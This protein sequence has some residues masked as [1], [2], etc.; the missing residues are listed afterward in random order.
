MS[1]DNN[2]LTEI[3]VEQALTVW[4]DFVEL[5]NSDYAL[6]FFGVGGIFMGVIAQYNSRL[7]S[8]TN[9]KILRAYKA[10][11]ILATGICVIGIAV[12]ATYATTDDKTSFWLIHWLNEYPTSVYSFVLCAVLLLAGL[13]VVVLNHPYP[14]LKNNVSG[15]AMMVSLVYFL[16]EVQGLEIIPPSIAIVLVLTLVAGVIVSGDFLT[17]KDKYLAKELEK[18]EQR[19]RLILEHMDRRKG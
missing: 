6:L 16:F 1:I 2:Q 11:K 13:M 8:L 14:D 17:N 4:S 10:A 3:M 12:I 15:F 18:A 9:K 19:K 5:F 7:S